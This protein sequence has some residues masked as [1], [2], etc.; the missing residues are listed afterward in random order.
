[1]VNVDVMP[2][3]SEIVHYDEVGIPLYIRK[4]ILSQYPEMRANCHWHEDLEFI[5]VLDGEM[6]YFINGSK[7]FLSKGDC[8]FVNARQMHY[9]Y[10]HYDHECIFTCILIHPA[11]LTA[12]TYLYKKYVQPLISNDSLMYLKYT[13]I[14]KDYN[15]IAAGL[16]RVDQLKENRS[17]GY[18]LEVINILSSLFVLILTCQKEH[19][20]TAKTVPDPK[21]TAQ[22]QMVAFIAGNYTEDLSLDQIAA[23]A[24]V[25]KSTCC[26]LFKTYIHQSPIDFLNAYRLQVSCHLLTETDKSISE[27]AS[28]CGFNHTSYF[29]KLFLRS[30]GCSPKV[31]RR[32]HI[33]IR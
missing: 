12:N 21:L 5:H 14:D 3:A 25:S 7:V 18:Q 28:L 19:P 2:D 22:K 1:M 17:V 32:S 23:S 16:R 26:R 27:I 9:G 6:N 10:A 8:L 31:Y 33:S 4:G 24:A 29:S 15:K 13:D 30:Y 11:L 20:D